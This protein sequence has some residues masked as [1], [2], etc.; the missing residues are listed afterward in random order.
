MQDRVGQLEALVAAQVKSSEARPAEPSRKYAVHDPSVSQESVSVGAGQIGI[1]K[2]GT[3]WVGSDHWMAILDGVCELKDS[4]NHDRG[5]DEIGSCS[6]KDPIA[7]ELLLGTT[8]HV[9]K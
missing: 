8:K 4:P 9:G 2:E 1:E 5:D 6:S 7:P 3:I